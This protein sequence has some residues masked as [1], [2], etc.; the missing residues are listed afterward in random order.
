MDFLGHLSSSVV[1]LIVAYLLYPILD[2]KM[3]GRT[4]ITEEERERM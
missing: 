1:G 4:D 2:R 3:K